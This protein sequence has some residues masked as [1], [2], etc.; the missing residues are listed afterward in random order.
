MRN[1]ITHYDV[2][3]VGASVGGATAAILFARQ[4]LR[5]ALV[6]RHKDMNAYK[7][8]CTHY[9]QESATPTIQRLGLAEAIETE[10]Y[11]LAARLRDEIAKRRH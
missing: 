4:G 5:V 11:E 1:S 6:E 10:Q 9:I 7:Q 3:I 2:V 8:V